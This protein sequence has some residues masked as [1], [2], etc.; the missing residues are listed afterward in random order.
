MEIPGAKAGGGSAQG[1][2]GLVGQ[3]AGSVPR[4]HHFYFKNLTE[5]HASDLNLPKLHFEAKSEG[6]FCTGN[7][8]HFDGPLN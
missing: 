8:C 6:A 1:A 7:R 3:T 5:P 4:R 2:F